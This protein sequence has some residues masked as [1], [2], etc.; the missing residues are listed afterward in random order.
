MVQINAKSGSLGAERL[1]WADRFSKPDL[2]QLHSH[3]DKPSTEL[4]ETARRSV[5]EPDAVEV[6]VA[7]QGLPWRWTLVFEHPNDPTRAFAYLVPDPQGV[8]I[9]VPLTTDMV[10]RLPLRRMKK[11]TRDGIETG[12]RIEQ[13]VW[14]CWDVGSENQL[15]EIMDIIRTKL[16]VIE[17]TSAST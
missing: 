5:A 3:Y 7:W 6:R 9:S 4:F 17:E 11:T 15:D 8:K 1:P 2:K 13:V 16:A 12:N 14:A 10:Q